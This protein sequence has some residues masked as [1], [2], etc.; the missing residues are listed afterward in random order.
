MSTHYYVRRM[1]THK[2]GHSQTWGGFRNPDHV[3]RA[4]QEKANLEKDDDVT[5]VAEQVTEPEDSFD[6]TRTTLG[7]FTRKVAPEDRGKYVDTLVYVDE[8]RQAH[9][10]LAGVLRLL[11]DACPEHLK[12]STDPTLGVMQ[13]MDDITNAVNEIDLS[14]GFLKPDDHEY[15]MTRNSHGPSW[16]RMTMPPRED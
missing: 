1:P 10:S 7:T 12:T 8:L 16:V 2:L 4:A 11:N 15:W 5:Y 14:T 3:C 6:Q 9:A 13:A